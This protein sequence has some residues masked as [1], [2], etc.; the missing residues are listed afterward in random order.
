MRSWGLRDAGAYYGPRF[1][2][3]EYRR[4]R[5]WLTAIVWVLL[6]AAVSVLPLIPPLRYVYILPS[7]LPS[8]HTHH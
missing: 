7:F 1:T 3:R 5:S 8:P 2:F 6:V 4:T